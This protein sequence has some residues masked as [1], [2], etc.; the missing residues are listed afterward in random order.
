MPVDSSRLGYRPAVPK[1]M[2]H[3]STT[4]VTGRPTSRSFGTALVDVVGHAHDGIVIVV[5][6]L[7]APLVR[8]RLT[9]PKPSPRPPDIAFFME[10]ATPPAVLWARLVRL[11][12]HEDPIVRLQLHIGIQGHLQLL[13][14]NR[15]NAPQVQGQ[16]SISVGV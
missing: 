15:P 13:S 5:I 6:V 7:R 16:G 2:A 3:V 4:A 10:G 12:A 8:L 14:T 9:T 1:G 11:G